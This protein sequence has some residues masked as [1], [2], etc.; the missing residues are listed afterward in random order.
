M[1]NEFI[2]A[3]HAF[4]LKAITQKTPLLQTFA[5]LEILVKN[6]ELHTNE[7]KKTV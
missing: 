5:C 7:G 3:Y 4:Y 6:E 2:R 1:I